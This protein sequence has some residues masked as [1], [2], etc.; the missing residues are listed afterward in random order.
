[1][2]IF[3]LDVTDKKQI[4]E[5]S[6]LADRLS[7]AAKHQA[8]H[9]RPSLVSNLSVIKNNSGEFQELQIEFDYNLPG[10]D[11]IRM[12]HFVQEREHWMTTHD[13]KAHLSPFPVVLYK[14]SEMGM[15]VVNEQAVEQL[16]DTGGHGGKMNVFD[17]FVALLAVGYDSQKAR[18][19][20]YMY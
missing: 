5:I 7:V 13:L 6:T 8:S 4:D 12:T 16:R 11:S 19:L 15:N 14:C 17:F 20:L 3:H 10:G 1:M 2:I 9:V 18:E